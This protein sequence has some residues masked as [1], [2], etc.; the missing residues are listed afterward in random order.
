MVELRL[1]P[2][3]TPYSTW[4]WCYYWVY[5]EKQEGEEGTSLTQR[6]SEWG[7]EKVVSEAVWKQQGWAC[8]VV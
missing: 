1:S 3:H 5:A 6:K 2:T 7:I 8:E 4:V